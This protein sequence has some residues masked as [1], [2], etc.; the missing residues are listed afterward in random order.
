MSAWG[1]SP[2]L[3]AQARGTV[4]MMDELLHDQPKSIADRGPLCGPSIYNSR[5]LLAV[6]RSTVCLESNTSIRA[7]ERVDPSL[8][9]VRCQTP[10]IDGH[11]NDG[12]QVA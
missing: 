9:T 12:N 7:A 8:L 10:G 6:R 11:H 4:S 1:N 5:H 2:E 3:E